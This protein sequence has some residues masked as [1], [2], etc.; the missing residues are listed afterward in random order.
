MKIAIIGSSQYKDKF[1]EH[2]AFLI[3]R[4]NEVKIP[5]FDEHKNFNELDVCEY[6]RSL[7]EWA[8]EI[9]IIWDNRSVGV[10]FD[11]GMAFALRKPC[12]VIYLEKKTFANVMKMYEMSI[13]NKPD[14][15]DYRM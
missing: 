5:A 7:I 14:G 2:E 11:F 9:H 10:L 3:R 4:G 1:I 12:K 8:D 6:N 13:F 15:P